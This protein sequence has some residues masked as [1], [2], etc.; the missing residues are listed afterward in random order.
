MDLGAIICVPGT[1]DCESCPVSAYCE[2]RLRGTPERLPVIPGAKP[3]KNILWT[4]PVIRSGD[5]VMMRLRSEKL[6]QGLWSYPMLEGHL[7]T[8]DLILS[9]RHHFGIDVINV[10]NAGTARHAFTH[11]FWNMLIY[12]MTSASDAAAADGYEMIRMD[13]ISKIALPAAMT[14]ARRAME[15]EFLHK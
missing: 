11:Q 7:D 1:P 10:R 6:L 9:I 12:T 13:D 5:R 3:P 2:S 15:K 14:A 4:V 8:N